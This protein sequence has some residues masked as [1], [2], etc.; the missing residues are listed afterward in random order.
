MQPAADIRKIQIQGLNHIT[1]TGFDRHRT[2]DFWEGVLGMP[3]VLDQRHPGNPAKCQ[4]FFDTGNGC[5]LTVFTDENRQPA[6]KAGAASGGLHHLGLTVS[7]AVFEAA[8]RRLDARR[9]KRSAPKDRGFMQGIYFEDPWGLLIELCCYSFEPP[10]GSTHTDVLTE[11][12]LIQIARGD[13]S[14]GN[15]HLADAIERLMARTRASLSTDR[16]PRNPY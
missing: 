5:L 6:A 4:L 2:V 10:A 11:A 13:A 16:G 9:I 15:C 8:T 3:L 7:R 14:I 1:L 12:H